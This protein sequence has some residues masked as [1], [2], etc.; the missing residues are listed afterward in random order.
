MGKLCVFFLKKMSNSSLQP[1]VNDGVN[2]AVN[3][4]ANDAAN[5]TALERNLSIQKLLKT[6]TEVTACIKQMYRTKHLKEDA[7]IYFVCKGNHVYAQYSWRPTKTILLNSRRKRSVHRGTCVYKFTPSED[8]PTDLRIAWNKKQI[9][10]K[11]VNRNF[12][13]EN[14]HMTIYDDKYCMKCVI[15]TS[16]KETLYIDPEIHFTVVPQ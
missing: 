7:T 9:Q 15:K 2:N 13:Y 10:L 3:D 5:D 6:V 11:H 1:P 8:L 16:R 14:L 4:V 12:V